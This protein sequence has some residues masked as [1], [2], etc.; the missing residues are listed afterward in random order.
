MNL[1]FGNFDFGFMICF[2]RPLGMSNEG[3][4][5]VGGIN[6]GLTTLR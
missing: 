4:G 6:D 2:K 1:G 3:F 5:W